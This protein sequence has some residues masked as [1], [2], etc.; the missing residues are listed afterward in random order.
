MKLEKY[1][2]Q[3]TLLD[4]HVR[5]IIAT[6]TQKIVEKVAGDRSWYGPVEGSEAGELHQSLILYIQKCFSLLYVLCKVRGYKAILKYFPHE[7]SRLE[8]LESLL[9]LYSTTEIIKLSQKELVN[10]LDEPVSLYPD[11]ERENEFATVVATS[12]TGHV[13]TFAKE[14]TFSTEAW[15][16]EYVAGLWLSVAILAPFHLKVIVSQYR[17]RPRPRPATA[18]IPGL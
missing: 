18:G 9:Y 4:G 14:S 2:E 1:Q 7:V 8:E 15:H 16:V 10:L 13:T 6:L 3:P 11:R 17:P 12:S 5:A